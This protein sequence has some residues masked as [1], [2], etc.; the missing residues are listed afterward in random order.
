VGTN[1][2]V[3]VSVAD[4]TDLRGFDFNV[5]WDPSLLRLA[6]VDFNTTLD[7]VW[8]N[9]N[10]VL[11]VN[12]SGA[13][14]YKLVAVSTANSFN[15]T[16]ATSLARLGFLVQ[17]PQSNQLRQSSIH[18]DTHKLS[19]SQ[20]NAITHTVTDGTYQITGGKP[21]LQISPTSL[22]C[23]KYNETFTIAITVSNEYS[24]TDFEFEIH[25]NTT[26]L[27]YAGVT[28]NTWGSGT[29]IVDEANG[30]ITGST[31]GTAV[32]GAQTLV[33]LQFN[34]TYHHIWKDESTIS[35]WKNIQNGT[36]Y[37]QWA[38]LSYT[39]YSDLGYVRDGLNQINVG[40][41]ATCTFSPIQ[42]DIDNNGSVD[43]SDLRTVAAYYDQPNA[44]Y[45]L[46]GDSTIDLFD[47][48]VVGSNF[49]YTY[50]P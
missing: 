46:T 36:I 38:N 28:W 7:G 16:T 32:S 23:R 18:F 50:S 34:T 20:Y 14:Y 12:Q 42:G 45:N 8:G 6:G 24:L 1:F 25:Y 48:V 2:W 5:T 4:I 3:N 35:G 27:D 43:I 41:D 19:D 31:L 11:A 9:G 39:G 30:N 29:I 21:T 37:I 13:G 10:W 22:T 40:P 47:L 26:L 15:S 44:T 33:T 17:D 49:G